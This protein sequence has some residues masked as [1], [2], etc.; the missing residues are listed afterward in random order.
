MDNRS[1]YRIKYIVDK[2]FLTGLENHRLIS[3]PWESGQYHNEIKTD[4]DME[5]LPSRKF[6]SNKLVLELAMIAYNV[7]RIIGQ[8]S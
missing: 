8:E 4:M 3:Y 7:L 1:R 2:P 5:K 6:E